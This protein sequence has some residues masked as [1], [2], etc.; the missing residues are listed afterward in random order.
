MV[1]DLL[2]GFKDIDSYDEFINVLLQLRS[3]KLSKEY[4][5]T[6]LMTILSSVL[7][8]LT[9]DDVRPISDAIED[10]NKTKEKLNTLNRGIKALSNL[11]KVYQNYN[12]I[13]LYKKAE[14]VSLAVENIN[15]KNKE[16]K[17]KEQNIETL[18]LSL[19]KIDDKINLLQ[20]E[21]VEITTKLSSIDNKDLKEYTEKLQELEREITKNKDI[22]NSIKEKLQNKFDQ[23]KKYENDL[24]TIEEKIYDREKEITSITEDILSL[25]EEV[26]I[27][28]ISLNV[29]TNEINFD[30]VLERVN[31]YKSKLNLVKIKLEEKEKYEEELSGLEEENELLNKEIENGESIKKDYLKDIALEIDNFKDKLN[32]LEGKS[33]VVKIDAEKKKQIF[34]LINNYDAINFI[35]AKEIYLNETKYYRELIQTEKLNLKIKVAK[36]KEQLK[37]KELELEILKNAK[38]E[39]Y[40]EDELLKD[41][42]N[43]LNN[44]KIPFIPLYKAIE[45]KENVSEEEKN[46][47]EEL[48]ISMNILNAK[49]VPNHD[50][51]KITNIKS[52]FLKR[53]K[54]KENNILTYFNII[55]NDV[56]SKEELKE[57]LSCISIDEKD[58]NYINKDKFELDFLI[59][60][61]S[62]K[63]ENK[64]IGLLK[65]QKIHQ[66]KVENAEKEVENLRTI[67]NNYNNILHS[68]KE[69]LEDID[70]LENNFPNNKALDNIASKIIK[71]TTSLE[72]L[73]ERSKLIVDK[74]NALNNSIKLKLEEINSVKENINIP[75]NLISYKNVIIMTEEMV[76]NIND[77]RNTVNAKDT[78]IEQKMS[79]ELSIDDIRR[80]IEYQNAELSEKT[81]IYNELSS[82]LN[83]IKEILSDKDYQDLIKRLD[84]LTKRK[85]MIPEEN[86]LLREEKGKLENSLETLKL[87]LEDDKANIENEKLKLEIKRFILKQEYDL[88]YVYKDE[89]LNVDKIINDLKSRENSDIAKAFENYIMA[90]NNYKQELLDYHLSTKEIFSNEDDILKIYMAKGLQEKEIKEILKN[91]NRQDMETVY[92][93]RKLNV[94]ELSDCLKEAI[95]ESENYIT[96]QERRIFEDV[97]LKTVGAKIRDKISSSKEWVKKINDIMKN[98]Q[99]DSNLSF[100]LEWKSKTAFTEDELDT[101]ELVRLFQIDASQL[102]ESD[103][104]KLANHF[105]SQINKELEFNDKTNESYS[106]IIFRVL[107]YRNWFE[108]KMYYKRK[109][110]E[111]RELTNKVFSVLSGGERAK[112]MY[113]PLFAAIYAKLL[114]ASKTSLKLIALDEAFA[115]VDNNNIREM[116][117]ILSQLDLDYILTSQVLWGDYDTVKDLSI[118][119]LIKDEVHKA[120]GVRTYRWNGKTKEI[121]E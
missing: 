19:K 76:K 98:T 119:E 8:P 69:K 7:Q 39:E 4:N 66:E 59:G 21:L 10:T 37:E 113:V 99:I 78:Y 117:D 6:K 88:N 17:E 2:F 43:T 86:N 91:T 22:I 1:N 72:L 67:I 35:K 92:Q 89:E 63:Y 33:K 108:F 62:K 90:F 105:Q 54:K 5:P 96:T 83:A 32:E 87:Q 80:E 52:T 93:G 81:A 45:F 31:K 95:Y 16:T 64:Y 44:L 73:S 75:L 110:G 116:F 74:I 34:D 68:I 40:I 106:N 41:A 58:N 30:Y 47:I 14:S 102:K 36:E 65:R 13:N 100:E 12:E 94:Y 61:P 50:L 103:S 25:N 55:E 38:E 24:K 97:L 27:Q 26:K 77:L 18:K 11:L 111:R 101:K 82:K 3:P 70:Y 115:G 71:I 118:C 57:I 46:K 20:K 121:L 48:L 42:A 9:N 23:E 104:N 15:K 53:G 56:I 28:D 29:L 120:V 112:S 84:E 114:S 49:I 79:K 51:A 109:S 85:N 107:D 60:Y